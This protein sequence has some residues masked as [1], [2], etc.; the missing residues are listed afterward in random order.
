MTGSSSTIKM[1][2]RWSLATLILRPDWPNDGIPFRASRLTIHRTTILSSPMAECQTPTVAKKNPVSKWS[3][4]A[5]KN[6]NKVT[7]TGTTVR[8]P[9][10]SI[11]WPIVKLGRAKDMRNMFR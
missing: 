5:E 6:T 11:C 9:Q 2:G 4:Y 3:L 10:K 1:R 8:H 7:A